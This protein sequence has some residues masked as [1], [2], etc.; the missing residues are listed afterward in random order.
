MEHNFV[1]RLHEDLR[2]GRLM[3]RGATFLPS[4]TT[5]G[6]RCKTYERMSR[7]PLKEV[8][9]TTP[10]G[11][12]LERRK[13]SVGT[14]RIRSLSLKEVSAL[15][16]TLR[17]RD[18]QSR[19][20][21]SGGALYPIETYLIGA[22][23]RYASDV[24]HYHPEA[25][26]LEHLWATPASFSMENLFNTGGALWAGRANAAILFTAVWRRNVHKYGNF[27]YDLALLEAGHMAQ[28]VLLMATECNLEARPMCG[29]DDSIVDAALGT[30]EMEEQCIYAICLG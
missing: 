2:T 4:G 8:V 29:F 18:D 12:L 26:A 11:D 22:I 16:G 28:N 9:G 25:H 20:Y 6:D 7:I 10:F 27:A 14:P 1:P 23:D 3:G 30:R 24:F 17:L 5:S 19:P 21:P 13:S 15:L